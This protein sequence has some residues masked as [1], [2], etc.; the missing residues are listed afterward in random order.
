MLQT[1]VSLLDTIAIVRD[2]TR[3]VYFER[4]WDRIDMDLRHGQPLADGL[5]DSPVIP[6]EVAQMIDSG[7]RAGRLGDVCSRV[8]DYCEANF[9][10]TVKTSTQFIEPI[11]IVVMGSV[12]G[13]VAIA[14]LTPIFSIGSAVSGG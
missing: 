2:V 12:I 14:L 13:F 1:G 6:E 8:A 3:N 11:M 10:Q 7:E 5:Y 9:D 4:L